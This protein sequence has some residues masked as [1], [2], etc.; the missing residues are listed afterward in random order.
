MNP[1]THLLVSWTLADGVK[2][3]GRDRSLVTW[4]GVLPDLDGLGAAADMANRLLGNAA[5][6]FY[7]TYHHSLLHGLVAALIMPGALSM[8][9]GRRWRVFSWGV[10]ASH[11]HLACDFVG[12]RGMEPGDIWPVSYLAPISDRLT[13]TWPGQWPVNGWPNIALTVFLILVTCI[14][15]VRRGYSPV[16]LFN[17]RADKAFVETLRRRC[18]YSDH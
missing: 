1:I 6:A 14:M 11:L 3:E 17:A 18:G 4:C 8:A 16:G 10:I 9:G 7:G 13:F 2:L 12:S 15:A 5:S